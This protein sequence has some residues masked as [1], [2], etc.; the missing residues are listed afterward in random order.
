VYGLLAILALTLVTLKVVD[1]SRPPQTNERSPREPV[2]LVAISDSPYLN[3]RPGVEYVGTD[4]CRKCHSSHDISFRRTGMGRSMAELD[5]SREPADGE[6]DH[7][8]SKRRYQI[9]RSGSQLWHRE[10]LLTQGTDE[11][12]LAEHPLKYVVGSGRHS[13]TYV[14]EIDGFLTESP[15]TWYSSKKAWGI[16]PGYDVN[17]SIAT[18]R[19]CC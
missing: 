3:T 12:L 19:A 13:R 15:A 1:W 11:V 10:L 7:S 4:V 9:K 2:P 6:F 8:V 14:V 16:S 17:R 18:T 5:L